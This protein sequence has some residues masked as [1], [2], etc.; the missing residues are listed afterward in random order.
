MRYCQRIKEFCTS[1]TQLEVGLHARSNGEACHIGLGRLGYEG[2]T[3]KSDARAAM[4]LQDP[5]SRAPFQLDSPTN[6]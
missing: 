1:R 4:K 6:Q 5:N 2:I 3:A